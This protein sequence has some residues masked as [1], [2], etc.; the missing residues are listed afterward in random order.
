MGQSPISEP[1][2]LH[3]APLASGSSYPKR[4]K[5]AAAPPND[6]SED[7][8]KSEFLPGCHRRK[9]LAIII[10]GTLIIVGFV[11]GLVVPLTT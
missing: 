8:D 6:Y 5:R 7:F 11:V 3:S 1:P 9:G 2:H 10:V 4:E